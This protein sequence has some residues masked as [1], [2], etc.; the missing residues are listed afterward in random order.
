MPIPVD[1][2]H[3]DPPHA[4]YASSDP[5]RRCPDI[6]KISKVT[7]YRPRYSLDNGLIRTVKWFQSRYPH[8]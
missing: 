5:K 7:G 6:S 8:S 2:V 3:I 1:I 4:V